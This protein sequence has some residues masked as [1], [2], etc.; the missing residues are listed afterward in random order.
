M[1][2][3]VEIGV[4]SVQLKVIDHYSTGMHSFLPCVLHYWCLVLCSIFIRLLM[5]STAPVLLRLVGGEAFLML[6]EELYRLY[7]LYFIVV[8]QC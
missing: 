3:F 4:G 6:L 2:L 7:Q 8:I 5:G 1:H